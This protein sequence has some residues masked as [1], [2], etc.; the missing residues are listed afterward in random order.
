MPDWSRSGTSR[1]SRPAG[2]PVES[3]R[4]A[5]IVSGSMALQIEIA[6]LGAPG[7]TLLLDPGSL[8][9][10][11]V[12]R[13]RELLALPVRANLDRSPRSCRSRATHLLRPADR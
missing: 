6:T 2:R 12:V 5:A 4:A 9:L 11:E 10:G 1:Q 13:D 8:L 7:R 3:V